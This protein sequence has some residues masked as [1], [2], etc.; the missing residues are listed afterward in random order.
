MVRCA[1]HSVLNT[2][3]HSP[4]EDGNQLIANEMSSGRLR[5]GLEWQTSWAA[6][7]VV[8]TVMV[9]VVAPLTVNAT[10]HH[11]HGM[12]SPYPQ[13]EAK[14]GVLMSG[15]AMDK[16][17][18]DAAVLAARNHVATMHLQLRKAPTGGT[19]LGA[20]HAFTT[21][22]KEGV[23]VFLVGGDGV[24]VNI[25]CHYMEVSG[26][27][28]LVVSP[29]ALISS[30]DCPALISLSPPHD[31][32]ITVEVARLASSGLA[33]LIPIVTSS[34]VEQ[35]AQV[36]AA[37]KA[38]GLT[39]TPPVELQINN[40]S[41]TYLRKTLAASPE[42]GVWISV[43]SDL[44]EIMI[45][46]G[47]ILHG[48]L[49]MLHAHPA[50]RAKL[51]NH[52]IARAIAEICAVCTVAWAGSSR[53]DDINRHHL[54]SVLYPQYPLVAALSYDAASLAVVA[55]TQNNIH[56]VSKLW[57]HL[58]AA[59]PHM[60]IPESD[61]IKGRRL[62]GWAVKM[63]LVAK[64]LL[65]NVVL[66]ESPWFIEGQT[67]LVSDTEHSW[68]VV[69]ESHF[70]V[71]MLTNQEI[72][73]LENLT[74]CDK[75]IWVEVTAHDPLTHRPVTTTWHSTVSPHV[76]LVPNGSTGGFS[77][78][79]WCPSSHDVLATETS[80]K[81]GAK[82][83][84]FLHCVTAISTRG[85]DRSHV[86]HNFI[87]RQGYVRRRRKYGRFDHTMKTV[88]EFITHDDFKSLIPQI[89]GCFGSAVGC[90]FC[91]MYVLYTNV[92]I[93]PGVCFGAC[94]VAIGGSC[95]TLLARG[96]QYT[97]DNIVT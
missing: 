84:E 37:G 46:V 54:Q 82:H 33:H 72:K 90:V 30:S 5:V 39:V 95:T 44:P 10:N 35:V 94:A 92:N 91:F 27:K 53:V 43:G 17:L 2:T 18:W 73:V 22:W 58:A 11:M 77:V 21:L 24:E 97:L 88:K 71:R 41:T 42:A 3:D 7:G 74:R 19:P 86:M 61:N 55:V 13:D 76:L 28:A 26:R 45:S 62:S 87:S 63:R 32:L 48:H 31:A 14:I 79:A 23:K 66:Q 81:G 47:H 1:H 83:Y 4:L 85:L 60:R 25:L 6:M 12:A 64:H 15:S 8:V 59:V 50:N 70:P 51:L 16:G 80:C 9:A 20:L 29:T 69:R 34:E 67:Q 78:R 65:G 68:V 56:D 75:N 36:M 93:N 52:P 57:E 38:R 49:I 89:G 40:I 96:I